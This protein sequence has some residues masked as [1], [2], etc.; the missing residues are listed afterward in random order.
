[1]S[2][3]RVTLVNNKSLSDKKAAGLQ[4][5]FTMDDLKAVAS[6]KLEMKPTVFYLKDGRVVTDVLMVKDGETLFV[7]SGEPFH[8]DEEGSEGRYRT[9]KIGVMGPGAVGKSAV[10]LRFIQ[11][12][13]VGDYDPTIEDSYRKVVTVDEHACLLEVLD[14][15]GQ[16]DFVALRSTWFTSSEGF[17][18]VYSVT[19][20]GSFE[21]LANFYEEYLKIR[22]DEP[23]LVLVANK[24]DLPDN[25]V[26]TEE[27][28]AIATKWKA[29][30]F[31]TSAK[32]GDRVE[33]VFFACARKLLTRK[34]PE[35]TATP[36]GW[37][38]FCKIL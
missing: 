2:G 12:A 7:S 3:L 24:V 32:T 18:F 1:M 10:S 36:G 37:R 5:G 38:K 33:E 8:A 29:S 16:E 15:A 25:K 23:P 27:G 14:T 4:K 22:E 19:S 20:R 17:I 28:Q 13:F 9:F 30:Y 21:N 34:E 31:E 26:T 6:E 35:T 11:N